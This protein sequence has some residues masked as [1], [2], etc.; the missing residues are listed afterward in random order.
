MLTLSFRVTG[1]L[2]FTAT[3]KWQNSSCFFFVLAF[4][5]RAIL[6][7]NILRCLNSILL[8]PKKI[9]DVLIYRKCIFGECLENRSLRNNFCPTIGPKKNNLLQ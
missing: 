5:M 1:F 7:L 6:L 3:K 2:P 9:D 4:V 8:I